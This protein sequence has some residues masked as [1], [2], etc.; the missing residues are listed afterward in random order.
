MDDYGSQRPLDAFLSGPERE[1]GHPFG[2]AVP[3]GV[4]GTIARMVW[5]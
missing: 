3:G 4:Y 1:N 5:R 2:G